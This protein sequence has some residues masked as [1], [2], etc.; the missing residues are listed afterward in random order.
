[1]IQVYQHGKQENDI[2]SFPCLPEKTISNKNR[3]DEVQKVM[4]Y[5]LEYIHQN[6]D[7]PGSETAI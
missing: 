2:S 1:M 7:N 5:E 6:K 4:Y 3:E